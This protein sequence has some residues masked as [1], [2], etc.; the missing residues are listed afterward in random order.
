M[1]NIKELMDRRG[2]QQKELAALCHVSNPTVSDWC[3]GKKNPS[4]KNLQ[5]LIEVFQVTS[6]VILGYDPVIP[7]ATQNRPAVIADQWNP[8]EMDY[9]EHLREHLRRNPSF[10]TL[11]SAAVKVRPENMEAAAAMLKALGE[12]NNSD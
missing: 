10:R 6:G 1:N 2:M 7:G 12:T 3:L 8:E 4:G 11:F 9:V 5:R